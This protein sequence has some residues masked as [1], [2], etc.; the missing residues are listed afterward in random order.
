MTGQFDTCEGGCTCGHV[1]YR[2]RE[3]PLI[4][5]C[6]HC[7]LCQ[8]QTGS[9]FVINALIQAKNV[10]VLSGSVENTMVSSP[11]GSGQRIARCPKCKVAVWSEYL[12]MTK[13]LKNILLFIRVGT[14]DNPGEQP[15][16]VHIYTSSKVPWVH[17][18]SDV[19]AFDGYYKTRDTWTKVSL[20]RLAALRA[21]VAE[22]QT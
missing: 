10:E 6:C 15:P 7:S 14:L 9:A 1:R 21:E 22:L 17:I 5:H 12:V 19:P 3:Q 13:G 11:G 18:P 8:R 16:D 4:I 20:E 2:L